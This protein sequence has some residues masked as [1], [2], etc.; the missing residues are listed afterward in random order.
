MTISKS[1]DYKERFKVEYEELLTRHGKLNKMLDM[2]DAD[3]REW[4]VTELGF[5]PTCPY[6]LLADQSEVM[7]KYLDI[8]ELRAII[9]GITL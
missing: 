3:K 1:T 5:K 2:W 4:N 8:L 9:E 7:Q 6:R